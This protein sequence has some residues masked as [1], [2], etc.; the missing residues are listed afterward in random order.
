[1]YIVVRSL[2]NVVESRCNVDFNF[3]KVYRVRNEV[4]FE[5]N[6]KTVGMVRGM[7]LGTKDC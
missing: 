7:W 6:Q 4:N 2:E 3:F 1:M 5:W